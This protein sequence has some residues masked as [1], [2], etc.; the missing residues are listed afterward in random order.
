MIY[1]MIAQSVGCKGDHSNKPARQPAKALQ[2]Y[3]PNPYIFSKILGTHLHSHYPSRNSF[4]YY[5]SSS[6]GAVHRRGLPLVVMG[7]KSEVFLDLTFLQ[8][9]QTS[10]SHSFCI[11]SFFVFAQLTMKRGDILLLPWFLKLAYLTPI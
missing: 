2:I 9:I 10:Q 1:S 8:C 4:T 3:K 7:I 11:V 6:A 5:P